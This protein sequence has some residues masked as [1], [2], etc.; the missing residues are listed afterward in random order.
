MRKS[1]WTPSIVPD[2]DDQTVYLVADDFGKR[3]ARLAR[4]RTARRPT[5]KRSSR[6]CSGPVQQ[7][8][9]RHRLQHRRALVGRRF[10]RRRPGAASPLRSATARRAVLPAGFC[11]PSRGPISRRPAAAADAPGVTCGLPA[12]EA[13]GD[14]RQGAFPGF[15]EPALRTSIEKVPGGERWIHEIKFDGY[16]VQVHLVNEAVKVFTRRGHDWTNRF[17]RSPTTPGTSPPA[18]R[19][20]TARSWCRP[21]MAPPISRSCKTN[22]RASRPRSCWSRSTCSTSMATTCES[23]R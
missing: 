19:S 10:G 5:L 7:P 4:E 12:Q 13:G 17:R 18:P 8:D 1:N 14:R 21:Q 9:P 23:C 20:S 15:I 11:R 16:R 22:S 6:T 3:S 2:E